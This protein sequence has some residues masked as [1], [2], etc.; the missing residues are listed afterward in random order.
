MVR[1]KRLNSSDAP[2]CSAVSGGVCVSAT[3]VTRLPCQP[4]PTGIAKPANLRGSSVNI[5]SQ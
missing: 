1:L 2:N 4:V 5:F 3:S